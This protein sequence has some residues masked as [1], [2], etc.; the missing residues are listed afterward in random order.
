MEIIQDGYQGFIT[1][2]YLEELR[3]K[4]DI[5]YSIP[6][7]KKT[8][9]KV[10]F[11]DESSEKLFYFNS[12]KNN[13]YSS[14]IQYPVGIY[15]CNFDEFKNNFWHLIPDNIQIKLFKKISGLKNVYMYEYIKSEEGDI[16]S[17]AQMM[18][19]YKNNY[20][21]EHIILIKNILRKL[22]ECA[23]EALIFLNNNSQVHLDIKLENFLIFMGDT[24]NIKLIDFGHWCD[25]TI[26]KSKIDIKK[27]HFNY[28]YYGTVRYNIYLMDY[29]EYKNDFFN[30]FKK[31]GCNHEKKYPDIMN[32]DNLIKKDVS[33]LGISLY[34]FM[35]YLGLHNEDDFFKE[36]FEILLPNMISCNIDKIQNILYCY[37]IYKNIMIKFFEN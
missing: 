23:F 36:I 31:I 35:R 7:D 13:S 2:N 6:T 34:L 24:I 27:D 11:W 14:Y 8:V 19:K 4:S 25:T 28:V 16:L 20:R 37:R 21:I 9:I 3:N 26:D 17:F 10:D 15:K 12:I 18:N 22:I 33:A 30:M 32:F 1:S 29:S 5:L